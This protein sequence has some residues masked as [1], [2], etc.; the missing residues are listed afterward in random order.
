MEDRYF[1]GFTRKTNEYIVSDEVE[2]R[3]VT[4]STVHRIVRGA[5]YD[6]EALVKVSQGHNDGH[7]AQDAPPVKLAFARGVPQGLTHCF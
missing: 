2:S 4:S 6:G 1:L 3:M 7:I 5:R